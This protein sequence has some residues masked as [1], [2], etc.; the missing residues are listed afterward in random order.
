MSERIGLRELRQHASTYVGRAA[1]GE[2][3]V[4]T[5]RGRAVAVLMGF[6]EDE[7]PI[8]RDIDA[9]LIVEAPDRGGLPEPVDLGSDATSAFVASRDDERW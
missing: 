5:N 2:R 9:G 6:D 4:V 3:L 7:D 8:A 1:A